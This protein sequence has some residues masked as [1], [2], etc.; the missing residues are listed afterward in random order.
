MPKRAFPLPGLIPG[1][2]YRVTRI[3]GAELQ[4]SGD[5]LARGLDI[6]VPDAFRSELCL[7]E[8]C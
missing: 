6:M 8:A 5:A 3:S 4:R 1:A 7:V 2:R